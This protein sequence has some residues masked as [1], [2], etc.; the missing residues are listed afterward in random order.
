VSVRDEIAAAYALLR[1]PAPHVDPVLAPAVAGL[2]PARV[3]VSVAGV[4]G[5]LLDAI[6]WTFPATARVLSAA[7]G[8]TGGWLEEYLRSPELGARPASTRF[9]TL[10]QLVATFPPFVRRCEPTVPATL[11][12][13]LDDALGSEIAINELRQPD[14]G[15]AAVLYRLK[16]PFAA[17]N[18]LLAPA[19]VAGAGALTLAPH[20]RLGA[21]G[22]DVAAL[23][24]SAR[25][26][27]AG[28]LSP[29]EW[30]A[31]L[32]TTPA[33]AVRVGRYHCAHVLRPSGAVTTIQLGPATAA[34]LDAGPVAPAGVV[35]E[36]EDDLI[37]LAAAGA[38]RAGGAR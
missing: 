38:L 18:G 19:A 12:S 36:V 29:A 5:E 21:Y 32:A 9:A 11:R 15:L 34:L 17:S 33:L 22:R 31:A 35:V 16:G 7:R 24:A 14:P 8:A 3:R 30:V 26:R 20:A 10:A 2:R 1:E 25:A 37:R 6:R 28:F 23:Q 4:L 13:L 27:V